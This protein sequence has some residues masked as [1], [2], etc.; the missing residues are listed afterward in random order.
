MTDETESNLRGEHV[1]QTSSGA[2]QS[3]PSEEEDGED[4]VGEDSW[5]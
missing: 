1:S 4:D 3:D 2:L 5:G